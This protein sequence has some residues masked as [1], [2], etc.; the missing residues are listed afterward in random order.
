[1]DHPLITSR[2]NL[3]SGVT[4]DFVYKKKSIDKDILDFESDE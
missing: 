3:D 2:L 1:L 4:K